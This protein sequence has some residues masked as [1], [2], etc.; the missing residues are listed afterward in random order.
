M[1]PVVYVFLAFWFGVV[2]MVAVAML[3]NR[4]ASILGLLLFAGGCAMVAI[5]R[6]L[7]IRD[8]EAIIA[9]LTRTVNATADTEPAT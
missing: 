7:G 9:F 3:F 1:H 8:R 2:A 6:F 4:P 5:G